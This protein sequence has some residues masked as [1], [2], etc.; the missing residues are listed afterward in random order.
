VRP[1]DNDGVAVRSTVET[2]A[3]PV[4]VEGRTLTLVARTR[5]L[6]VGGE[7]AAV[8]HVHS[9]PSHVEVLDRNG[10]HEVVGVVDLQRVITRTI[11]VATAA[12]V[13]GVRAAQAWRDR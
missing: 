6:R 11:I 4:A 2:T 12:I 1:T 7:H 10:Q 9:R 3:G 5:T 13:V 8:F